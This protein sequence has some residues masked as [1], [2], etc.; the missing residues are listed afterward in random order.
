MAHFSPWEVAGGVLPCMYERTGR[1][2]CVAKYRLFADTV[3]IVHFLWIVFL[4]LG[5]IWG[6]KN[7]TVRF[8]HVSGLIFSVVMQVFDWYCPLTILEV[9]LRSK[10]DPV[11]AYAGSFIVYYAE[12]VVYLDLSR[13]L[14]FILTILLVAFNAGAYLMKGRR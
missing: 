11:H 3:V 8:V 1:G 10:S 4:F 14:I 6:R 7:K 2:G 9:W 13:G 12:K 5:A